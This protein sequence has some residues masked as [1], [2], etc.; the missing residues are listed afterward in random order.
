MRRVLALVAALGGGLALV[1]SD[2]YSADVQRLAKAVAHEDDHVTA[3]ELAQWIRDGKPGL[4][5]I[6]V[7]TPAE[8]AKDHLPRAENVPIESIAS[9]AFSPSD[10]IVLLSEGGA[11]AAQAWVLLQTLGYRN[12]YFLRGGIEQSRPGGRRYIPGKDGC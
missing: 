3:E 5:L 2:P 10:T 9:V 6:D 12:V 8:Y 7:R 11:H 4:R 1:A